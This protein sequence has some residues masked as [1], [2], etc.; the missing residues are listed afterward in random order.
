MLIK[1]IEFYNF[2][3]F[4]GERLDLDTGDDSKSV[5][6]IYGSNHAGKTT[7]VKSL[8]WCLYPSTNPFGVDK[9]VDLLNRD[10]ASATKKEQVGS[11]VSCR[12]VIGLE[13]RGKAY[14]VNTSVDY[15][16]ANNGDGENVLEPKT[17]NPNQTL[18]VRDPASGASDLTYEGKDASREIEKILPSDLKD[19]FF[20]DGESNPIEGNG[21]GG[22]K[23]ELGPSVTHIMNFQA[24][25][26]LIKLFKDNGK[27]ICSLRDEKTS[28]SYERVSQLQAERDNLIADNDKRRENN[29]HHQQE[30]EKIQER[31]QEFD[32]L[33]ER[34]EKSGKLQ[35]EITSD[36]RRLEAA[37]EKYAES[38]RQILVELGGSVNSSSLIALWGA[39]K[40]ICNSHILDRLNE[41]KSENSDYPDVTATAIKDILECGRC[42]CG[43]SIS[44]DNEAKVHLQELSK[45]LSPNDNSGS[46]AKLKETFETITPKAEDWA[47]R[48]KIDVDAAYQLKKEIAVLNERIEENAKELGNFSGDIK[49]WK[50]ESDDCTRQIGNYEGM[51]KS[52]DSAIYQNNLRIGYCNNEIDRLSKDSSHNSFIDECIRVAAEISKIA[53][54]SSN[55]AREIVVNQLKEEAQNIYN[56]IDDSNAVDFD[57]DPKSFNV[58][59]L[60]KGTAD[61]KQLSTAEKGMRNLA[62]VASL[63]H[64]VANRGEIVKDFHEKDVNDQ[65][66]L[67]LDAPFSNFDIENEKRACKV[68]PSYCSQLI[69]TMLNKD[70]DVSASE[71][72]PFVKKIY[73]VVS[74]NEES[75]DSK[76]E[77]EN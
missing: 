29:D 9:L 61:E 35:Q 63:V 31:K 18:I 56:A 71:I 73:R 74:N 24:R 15:V 62:F 37:H 46:L 77:E 17:R 2:R 50:R 65:L 20:Y 6:L 76:F 51:I 43:R 27:I 60:C 36:K 59:L 25:D 54:K 11:K 19:Y 49:T 55:R 12:V 5:I 69:I 39:K 14:V 34:N 57:V 44:N 33:L 70:Q 13:H 72:K 58:K 28:D 26:D 67:V 8:I 38:I 23:L 45:H 64:M 16:V 22:K 41:I 4:K 52:N 75:S 40:V 7:F 1:F 10:V 3:Q 48:V 32:D 53:T 42:V 21:R 30:I 68:L 66:P 47:R